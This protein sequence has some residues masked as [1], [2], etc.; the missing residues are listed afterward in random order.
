MK[1]RVIHFLV[2]MILI[3]LFSCSDG[4]NKEKKD[5]IIGVSV[6]MK[7]ADNLSLNQIGDDIYV[8]TIRNPW[9][10]TRRMDRY[11]LVPKGKEM[12]E[13]LPE[14]TIVRTPVKN[15]LVYSALHCGLLSELGAAQSI[16]GVCNS[17]FITESSLKSRISRG[18]VA[19]CGE[20]MNPDIERIIQLRPEVI[21]LS[22]FENNDRYGKAIQMGI[23]VIECADYMERTPLGQAEWMRFYGL[24]FG[25][26][27]EAE[28]RFSEIAT[29]YNQLKDKA[30]KI[31]KKPGV[32]MDQAYQGSW[33]V[34]GG[35]STMGR[36][37]EDAGGVNPF[38]GYKR[39]GGVMLAP[40]MVLKEGSDADI[41]LVRYNQG[42]EKGLKELGKDAAVNSQFKAYREGRVY[43][44]N[45]SNIPFFDE[46]PFHPDLLLEELYK[47]FN[48]DGNSEPA[49]RYFK[50]MD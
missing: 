7:Y 44:C 31:G 37:I 15:A 33:S 29:R 49:L 2:L 26:G 38:S 23:P 10:T 16:G 28:E 3:S 12:P 43:G 5:E 40:E 34:P 45:T 46:T 11:I 19:D 27:K 20:G 22:P 18:E 39:S 36:L 35:E 13:N 30:S 17:R 42:S 32:L 41:W 24:L 9:D 14:G 6:A 48:S 25:K 1:K 50:K 47:I 4:G 21:M 8:A